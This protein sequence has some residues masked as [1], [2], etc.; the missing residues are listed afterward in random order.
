M[1]NRYFTSE[2]TYEMYIRNNYT[3]EFP[4]WCD[5]DLY[6][7]FPLESSLIFRHQDIGDL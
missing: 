6:Y 1:L 2:N 5:V 4:T 7:F 3:K